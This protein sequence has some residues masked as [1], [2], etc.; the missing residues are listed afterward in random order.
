[1]EKLRKLLV[2]LVSISLAFILTA[3]CDGD[4]DDDDNY[5]GSSKQ[6]E[7]DV[8]PPSEETSFNFTI[9][10]TNDLHGC[11]EPFGRYDVGGL[12]RVAWLIDEIRSENNKQ[13]VKTLVLDGGDTRDGTVFNDG[14]STSGIWGAM[15]LAGYDAT[16]IGNHD[17][18]PGILTQY[19]DFKTAFGSDIVTDPF[20][21]PQNNNRMKVLWGNI[22]PHRVNNCPG[23]FVAIPEV[24]KNSI[25]N[26]FS[27]PLAGDAC[28]EANYPATLDRAGFAPV[29]DNDSHIF[30]QALFYD[31]EGVRI[32]VIGVTNTEVLYLSVPGSPM[33]EL[34]D[35]AV[36]DVPSEGAIFYHP[37][38]DGYVSEMIDYVDDPDGNP[39][40]DDGADAIILVTHSGTSLDAE[41]AANCKGP[42]SGRYVDLI[43]GGHS[44][45]QINR[46]V[47]V[48][49][50]G[51]KGMP[52]PTSYTYIVQADWGGIFLGRVDLNVNSEGNVQLANS[53]LIQVDSDVPEK[54][55]VKEYIEKY[56]N[57]TGGVI[58][59]FK[60][61]YNGTRPKDV[62]GY[63][64]VDLNHKQY[65]GETPLTNLIANSYLWQ[66]QSTS[67]F[68]IPD[69]GNP[70]FGTPGTL[71]F[72][73]MMPFV[74]HTGPD[75]DIIL[76]GKT[77][78]VKDIFALMHIHNLSSDATYANTMHI[79]EV[80]PLA[81]SPV[82]IA[83]VGT[84]DNQIDLFL[85]L[86]FGISDLVAGFGLGDYA[87]IIN[88]YLGE[89]QWAGITFTVD[90]DAAPFARIDATSIMVGGEP[91]DP[92]KYYYFSLCSTLA[93][94]LGPIFGLFKVA[95][96]ELDFLNW[97]PAWSESNVAE[98][99][100][101]TNY[102]RDGLPGSTIT[103]ASAAVTGLGMRT[104]QPD[105]TIQPWDISFTPSN[106]APG[107]TVTVHSR[108]LNTGM[109]AVTDADVS[110][111]CDPTPGIL[112]DNPDGYT[113]G[114]TG[115]ATYD[116]GTD[117]VYNVPAF[118]TVPGEAM[119]DGLL[120]VVP[121]DWK[122]GEYIVCA[123]VKNLNAASTEIMTGNNGG[124][125]ICTS[126][127]VK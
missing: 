32:A 38:D 82:T 101:L 33:I 16:V 28:D 85:E 96:P 78:K 75:M 92:A 79:F 1:M 22:N 10:H 30:R 69:N 97:D 11:A 26:G 66:G 5:G 23:E 100:A 4:D 68:T 127:N 80:K 72:S 37:I 94:F 65:V 112:D 14:T 84:F 20:G 25:E 17:H 9:L 53:A 60:A 15:S 114:V 46:A 56:Y 116:I 31:H 91:V 48:A 99:M 117:K 8:K 19:D 13:G 113:D 24:A 125:G 86:V 89:L 119:T 120:W 21:V 18:I 122:P 3:G 57:K 121:A 52:A 67:V 102:I 62:V 83:G 29:G 123:Q 45:T 12:A 93:N 61:V 64:E 6:V 42:V 51:G 35:L 59:W 81:T 110:Y 55:N 103:A 54:K 87:G 104:V 41:T 7:I 47:A 49:H 105:L 95:L 126:L 77:L 71:N 63:S 76:A 106:P 98:W 2:L 111:N 74:L 34:G 43:V 73:I 50:G 27:Q 36:P 109:T 124:R 44:H 107:A 58:D 90:F 108:V 39:A 70:E 115:F 40:T 88:S 118:S